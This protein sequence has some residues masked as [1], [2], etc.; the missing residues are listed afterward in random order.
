M[1]NKGKGVLLIPFLMF[2]N[3]NKSL[4]AGWI[5]VASTVI[6]AWIGV[7]VLAALGSLVY[8]TVIDQPRVGVVYQIHD[9][10]NGRVTMTTV[11][12]REQ[13]F[14]FEE[15]WYRRKVENFSDYNQPLLKK[16]SYVYFYI[17]GSDNTLTAEVIPDVELAAV[18]A[19][20][21]PGDPAKWRRD[22][23][24]LWLHDPVNFNKENRV[25]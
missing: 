6:L 22:D 5:R 20:G 4:N 12:F 1:V 16:G 14:P 2:T 24:Y 13:A 7:L 10:K 9:I 11:S 8:H 17:A 15:H 19:K 3:H 25:E 21:L 18:Y 23:F